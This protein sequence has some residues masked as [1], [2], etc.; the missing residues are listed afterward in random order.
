[1]D[2]KVIEFERLRNLLHDSFME[3]L[4]YV[5]M[6]VYVVRPTCHHFI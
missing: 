5:Y 6:D 3:W 4:R 2:T 1:M